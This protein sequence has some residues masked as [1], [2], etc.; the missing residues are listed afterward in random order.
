MVKVSVEY[1]G[2]WGYKPRFEELATVIKTKVPQAE[3]T[4]IVGRSSSFEVTVNDTLIF[5]KLERNS[6]PDFDEIVDAVI[7]V[8]GGENS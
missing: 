5:S 2:G 3:V 6:F 8:E 4:G 1:C 7:A